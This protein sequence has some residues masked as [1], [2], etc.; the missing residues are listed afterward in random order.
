M[1]KSNPFTNFL[2]FA[3]FCGTAA[4]LSTQPIY[5]AG[6]NELEDVTIQVIELNKVPSANVEAIRLPEP[7]LGEMRDRTEGVRVPQQSAPNH[8]SAES[9]PNVTPPPTETPPSISVGHAPK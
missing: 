5:A 4:S 8:V 9:N 1:Y 3:A 2:V 6:I 7:D